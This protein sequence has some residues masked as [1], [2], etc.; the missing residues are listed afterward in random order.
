MLVES[1]TWYLKLL[2]FVDTTD[3]YRTDRLFGL[4]PGN[5]EVDRRF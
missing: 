4:L 3:I 5:G 2:K 1:N